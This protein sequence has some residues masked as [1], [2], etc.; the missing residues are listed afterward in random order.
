MVTWC[1]F[2]P[3][4]GFRLL[5]FENRLV[6]RGTIAECRYSSDGVMTFVTE[7]GEYSFFYLG[8][9]LVHLANGDWKLFGSTPRWAYVCRP[10]RRWT[11]HR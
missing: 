3:F 5:V 10:D 1:H 9:K 7:T 2:G 6:D 4:I 11:W 8:P